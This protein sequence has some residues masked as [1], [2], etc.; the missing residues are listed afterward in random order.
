[1]EGRYFKD[2]VEEYYFHWSFF[3]DSE[4]FNSQDVYVK[5]VGKARLARRLGFLWYIWKTPEGETFMAKNY[6]LW[7]PYNLFKLTNP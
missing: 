2:Y 7:I 1:M 6:P 3:P 5:D 4:P